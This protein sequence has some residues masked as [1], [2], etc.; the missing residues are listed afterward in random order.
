MHSMPWSKLLWTT[1]AVLFVRFAARADGI[2]QALF[3]RQVA[4][5]LQ[6]RCL[7]C[8]NAQKRR[9]GLNLS[10]RQGLLQ[11]GE[12][13]PA[14]VPGD[15][16]KSLLVQV[17]SGP[18][19]QMPK[20]GGPLQLDET[21]ALRR[22]IDAG[23]AWPE[24]LTLTAGAAAARVGP[25][26]WSLRPLV[27]PAI[28]RGC[29]ASWVRS[30]VDV[31]VLAALEAKG[32]RP[33]PP[34]DRRTLIRRV[35]YDLLG[36]PPTPEEVAAFLSDPAPNAYEKLVERLLASPH[37]GERWGRHWLD[38][39]HYGD[40]HGYDKDKRRD[41]AWPY[42]DYVI[43]ALNQDKP[44][45][46]LV[47]EQIA[48]DVLYPGDPEGLIATGFLAAGPWDF[49]GHVELREGT[50]EKE[51]T[52]MLDRDD[53][54]SNT[55][56][57]F[58]SL[59]AHCARCH[60]HKFDPISKREYYSLQA[61][62]AGIDRGDR[63]FA[64]REMAALLTATEQRRQAI[65]WHLGSLLHQASTRTN[66]EL[67]QR[68][69]Q[70]K[71]LREQLA[72]LPAPASTAPSPTN[73]YHSGISAVPDV[74][75]WVQI[76][77]GKVYQLTSLR[78]ITARPTD[79]PDSPGFGFPLRL[80]VELADGPTFVSP[81][82]VL[83]LTKE[84]I[85]N[86]G[87]HP[88]VI[89]LQG[90]SARFIRVTAKRLWKRT[91]DYVF[92]LA[93]MQAFAG[94]KNLALG[95]KVYALD[96][97][98]A[99]RWSTRYLVDDF[100]SRKR[101]PDLSDARERQRAELQ[102]HIQ[103]IAEERERLA[104]AL[105][106]PQLRTELGQAKAELAALEQQLKSLAG[107]DQVYAVLSHPPRPIYELNRGDVEQRGE[108]VRPGALACVQGARF[109]LQNEDIVRE[110][111]RRAALAHWITDPKNGLTWRSIVNRVWHYHFGRGIVDTPNDF[112]WNGGR[113]THSE[114][115][116][117]LA[118]QFLEEG[119]SLKKLHR[120][121]LLSA[122]YRQSSQSTPAATRV[123][124][125]NRQIWRM[126]RQRLEAEEIRDAV[127][128]VT[129]QLD[130]RMGGPGFELFRFKDD[131][132]PIYDHSAVDRINDPAAWRRTVYR[133]TVR[134]VPNPFL[135]CLDC[136][137]PNI[138]TPV[139][140]TT[141]TALQALALL[142]DPFMTRQAELFAQRLR[143]ISPDLAAQITMGYQLALS[144]PP[145][146]EEVRE[147]VAYARRYG[148]AN[149]C[150]LLFNMNEFIFID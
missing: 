72:A 7:G 49:V 41:H 32:L 136:A 121:I 93:E 30:P 83:D 139:R 100:D 120:L 21:T 36:V 42:R 110:G 116:D 25:D 126:N 11:G 130:R 47:E 33:S 109:V 46:R 70:L 24:G 103:Q 65:Q 137:D 115:L 18:E 6:K 17:I 15:A 26:W 61:V 88:Y 111:A 101:L 96:S 148:L 64:S 74:D 143:Q 54:V 52:R 59:T 147:L 118:V 133:F 119:Q 35:T 19:P 73:G 123:D 3:T 62:F 97:I 92:A 13:G 131:H 124:A 60:D 122:T 89:D 135:E 132:S 95:A 80:R 112:G 8:H 9:G 91:G 150:R 37:Y 34:A 142:N 1:A 29:D 140:S 44:Y 98:E 114:L 113:P 76:D 79:F 38:V 82:T 22:W 4:P 145:S 40:T 108:F 149:C 127:L 43:R 10:T 12:T 5:V 63:P 50:V 105:L 134:S 68:D 125:D 90:Q 51:K 16:S 55:V 94:S 2:D 28:P 129:G 104:N 31:F 138:N 39:V 69:R 86:P 75:K 106:P 146:A 81:R 107:N 67:L 144:R 99:G 14:I 53:M 117:W 57:T 27:R 78:L 66:S 48:G 128:A 20:Q 141:L 77:L 84:D 56:S 58:V 23:A 85:P 87:Q 71:H 45:T 102:D